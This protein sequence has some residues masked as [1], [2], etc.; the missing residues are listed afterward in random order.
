MFFA[1]ATECTKGA[2]KSAILSRKQLF[3][4][5]VSNLFIYMWLV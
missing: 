1:L 2:L 3:G 5:S 4:T